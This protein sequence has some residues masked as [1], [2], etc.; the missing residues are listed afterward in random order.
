MNSLNLIKLFFIGLTL[1]GVV[2]FYSCSDAEDTGCDLLVCDNGGTCTTDQF[3]DAVCECPDGFYGTNCEL[4][5][6]SIIECPANSTCAEDGTGTC[7]CDP[8]YEPRTNPDGSTDCGTVTRD[9]YLGIFVGEDLCSETGSSTYQA[10]ISA[11]PSSLDKFLI[12]NFG[13][14]G[15]TVAAQ[16]EEAERFSIPQQ[17][18]GD[19]R[20]E[21]T[22]LGNVNETTGTVAISYQVTIISEGIGEECE[23]ILERN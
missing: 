5:E 12:D 4:L 17:D 22:T 9:K 6:C 21:S 1:A 18:I 2:S 16:V 15:V 8:G 19:I 23:M 20:F 10:T 3:G 14:Y 13:A 11:H 7:N